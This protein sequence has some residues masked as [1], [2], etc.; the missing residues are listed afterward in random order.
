M[1]VVLFLVWRGGLALLL[2]VLGV[3]GR[4]SWEF[5]HLVAQAGHR[6]M[7]PVGMVAA[8][9]LGVWI[10]FYGDSHL[11]SAVAIV[12]LLCL[13]A[14][15]RQGVQGFSANALLTLG[16]VLYTGLL[17]SAPLWIIRATGPEHRAE[18]QYLLVAIVACIWLADT[19]AY[20]F[21][22]LW[23]RR[24]LA[25]AISPGKTVVGFIGGLGGGLAPLAL[26]GLL[27]SF[28]TAQLAGLFLL[29]ALGGQLGDL[30]ESAIKRDVGAKDAP[31]L[32]PG[33]GGVLDRFDSYF[34]AFP[35]AYLYVE[36]F[37]IF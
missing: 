3:I 28:S 34:F 17:G 24:K 22:R 16:G 20:A 7:R 6:P 37:G 8:V 25:P 35:L 18:V 32:I 29:V 15:L 23:G 9:G 5:Y 36:I 27:P 10:Y 4:G 21:G 14:A 30:V 13:V 19:A 12:V 26:H 2:L 33:H 1:P 31:T 11:L